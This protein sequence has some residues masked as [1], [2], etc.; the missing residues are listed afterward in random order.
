MIHLVF[1]RPEQRLKLFTHG[2]APAHHVIAAS[3]AAWGNI[4]GNGGSPPY[5]HDCC[6]APGHYKLTRVERFDPP[7]PSEGAGQVYVEDL[8]GADYFAMAKA[9]K[10]KGGA[11]GWAI[12]GITLA[13]GELAKY[14]RAEVMIHGGG[15]NLGVPACYA[16]R[17]P[18]LRTFG[19]TRVHNADLTMLMDYLEPILASGNQLV[20]FSCV[21]DPASVSG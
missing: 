3:G 8:A 5:G 17:Q 18:L 15:S 2:I 21:G 7:V 13:V 10:V 19:C 20:I 6:I 16:P 9:G 4:P 12:G 11:G 14:G 1:D